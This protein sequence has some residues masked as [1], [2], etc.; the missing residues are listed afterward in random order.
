MHRNHALS[1]GGLFHIPSVAE[2]LN[3]VWGWDRKCR[4]T[5][6]RGS[7]GWSANYPFDTVPSTVSGL[8]PK[9]PGRVIRKQAQR[10]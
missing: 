6:Q 10:L 5:W 8:I 2:C 3:Q 9:N 7:E 4:E 1:S